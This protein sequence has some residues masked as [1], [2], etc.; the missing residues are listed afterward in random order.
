MITTK[1]AMRLSA[2][3][4]KTGLELKPQTVTYTVNGKQKERE[5][6]S[7][8]LGSRIIL[9]I[10]K[11]AYLAENEIYKLIADYKG[12][13]AREAEDADIIAFFKEL[14]TDSGLTDFFGRGGK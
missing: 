6:T 1:M 12:C 13:T 2:I 14:I 7:S 5:E 4:D 3:L 11:K 9:Q 10:A 8:E